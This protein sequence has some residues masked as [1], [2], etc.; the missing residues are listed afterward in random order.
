MS[1]I[2]ADRGGGLTDPLLELPGYLLK[3]ASA[4]ALN[5]LNHRLAALELRHTDVSLLLLIRT[6]PGI[7]QS[8]AGRMLDI[9]RANMVP[10]VARLEKRG[11]L[12]RTPV[13]GRS[14]AIRLTAAGRTL[15]KKSLAVVRAFERDLLDRVPAKLRQAVQPILLALWRGAAD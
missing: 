9:Q 10:L 11:L 13:D 4:A 1:A 14:R 2:R 3:R 6:N 15:A 5:S 7:T 8:Q 12:R